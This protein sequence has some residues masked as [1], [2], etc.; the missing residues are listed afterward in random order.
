LAQRA[1]HDAGFERVTLRGVGWAPRPWAEGLGVRIARAELGAATPALAITDLTLR[2]TAASLAA[3]DLAHVH[4]RTVTAALWPQG[5]D[6]APLPGFTPPPRDPAAAPAALPWPIETLTVERVTATAGVAGPPVRLALDAVG[7]RRDAAGLRV[8]AE[9]AALDQDDRR[10]AGALAGTVALS[11][12]P[13]ADLAWEIAT[14]EAAGRAWGPLRLTA[15][16]EAQ[17]ATL[18]LTADAQNP[19]QGS[20][21]ARWLPA[22]RPASRADAPNARGDARD[23]RDSKDGRDVGDRRVRRAAA[24][25]DDTG[26]TDRLTLA[27]RWTL[28]LAA[29]AAALPINTPADTPGAAGQGRAALDLDGRLDLGPAPTLDARATL[30]TEAVA[31][32]GRVSAADARWVLR[33]SGPLDRLS[34]RAPEPL[35]VRLTPAPALWPAILTDRAPA[36]LRVTLADLTATLGPDGLD[37]SARLDAG[38]DGL[39]QASALTRV[40]LRR[41]GEGVRLT[42]DARSLDARTEPVAL[43]LGDAQGDARELR[44]ALDALSGRLSVA[45]DTGGRLTGAFEGSV[46]ARAD[47]TLGDAT[48]TGASARWSGRLALDDDAILAALPDACLALGLDSIAVGGQ[49]LSISALPCLAAATDDDGAARPLAR[50]D[51]KERRLTLALESPATDTTARLTPAPG[52]GGGREIAGTWPRLTLDAEAGAAAPGDLDATLVFGDG[53]LTLADP[54]LRA[55]GIEGRVTVAQGR[56]TGARLDVIDLLSTAEPALWAPLTLTA[57]AAPADDALAEPPGLLALSARLSDL[58]GVFVT[59]VTGR[60]D[61]TSG[62][63]RAQIALAPIEFMAGVAELADLSPLAATVAG[64]LT[65]RVAGDAHLAWTAEGLSD[66]GGEVRVED[67]DATVAGSPV[68]GIATRFA[69]DGLVPPTTPEPQRVTLDLLDMGAPFTDGLVRL[70]ARADGT[71]RVTDARFRLAGGTLRADP[72]IVDTADPGTIKATL[73]ADGV[74]LGQLFQVAGIDGLA[75]DGT[76][77][78]RLPVRL[79]R[80]GIGIDE[81]VLQAATTGVLRYVPDQPP[82]F[83]QGDDVRTRMLRQALQNFHYDTLSLTLAGDSLARQVLTLSAAGNNPDFLDGHPVE[84]NVSLNGPLVSAVESAARTGQSLRRLYEQQQ[85]QQDRQRDPD[86]PPERGRPQQENRP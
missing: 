57:S 7:V 79:G 37:A 54:G 73:A 11:P 40:S 77:E 21:T 81:G 76:L 29:L 44:A 19:A 78:G 53:A 1:L 43:A 48:L 82:A 62:A 56:L 86:G 23:R 64:D 15:S 66:S 84:L 55:Q 49:R 8:A 2:A 45:M 67:L 13:A 61:P 71:V 83:L 31:I 60:H 46:R 35:T 27:G 47:A 72:F 3:G 75:G 58:F 51:L 42:L 80:D 74:S 22:G 12:A 24:D 16:A 6:A 26:A 4:A 34:L 70:D 30:A 9:R 33:A 41:R 32:P 20:L 25:G 85:Q 68:K 17:G 5:P 50:Y 38:A 69:L 18:R 52:G 28:P 59:E 36:P 39:G 10:L 63:G 14:A 65:G